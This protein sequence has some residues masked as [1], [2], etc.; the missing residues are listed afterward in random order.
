MKNAMCIGLFLLSF[1]ALSSS[2]AE[3]HPG[4]T[5]G[6]HQVKSTQVFLG[7][8]ISISGKVLKYNEVM[9]RECYYAFDHMGENLSKDEINRIYNPKGLPWCTD[10]SGGTLYEFT[11][12]VA[13]VG[14]DEKTEYVI[15]DSPKDKIEYKPVSQDAFLASIKKDARAIVE[16]S[17][18]DGIARRV[19]E[20]YQD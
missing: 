12:K 2:A 17:V 20:I 16:L 19:E 7:W 13:S 9:S 3:D 4:A 15:F 11:E 8:N 5:N 6:T 14:V 1:V 10:P 18:Q